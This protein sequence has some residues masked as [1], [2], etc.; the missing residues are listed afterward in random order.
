M[1]IGSFH[2]DKTL[3]PV[4]QTLLIVVFIVYAERQTRVTGL[5]LNITTPHLVE[6]GTPPITAGP[7]AESGSFPNGAG[8][9]RAWDLARL[10][11][12]IEYRGM[13]FY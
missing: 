5:L 1:A 9:F 12:R 6:Y 13:R 3:T 10:A 2:G 8:Q 11:V 7:W 4:S